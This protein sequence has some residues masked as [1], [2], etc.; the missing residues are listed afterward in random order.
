M[1]LISLMLVILMVVE[2]PPKGNAACQDFYLPDY[3]CYQTGCYACDAVFAWPSVRAD[4]S[5][6]LAA[7]QTKLQ[8]A[9]ER[10]SQDLDTAYKSDLESPQPEA[11]PMAGSLQDLCQE[12]QAHH[13]VELGNRIPKL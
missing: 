8:H 4:N 2:D 11:A 3:Q 9:R 13:H 12:P 7:W 6:F 10:F 5:F 1:S